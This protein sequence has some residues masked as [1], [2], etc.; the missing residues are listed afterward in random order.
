MTTLTKIFYCIFIIAIT[1]LG[2]MNNTFYIPSLPLIQSEFGISVSDTQLILV[3]GFTFFGLSQLV[4][5]PLTDIF[6]RRPIIIT[7][8]SIFLLGSI[9]CSVATNF[10]LLLLGRIIEGLGIG[11]V[12]VIAR[13]MIRDCFTGDKLL[14]YTSYLTIC[15]LITPVF[16]PFLGGIVEYYLGWHW[17]FIILVI[18]PF[19]LISIALFKLKETRISNDMTLTLQNIKESYNIVLKS[20]RF[21]GLVLNNM[22]TFSGEIAFLT[23]AS[24]LFQQK[25][26]YSA[27]EFS[28]IPLMLLPSVILGN[29]FVIQLV[30]RFDIKKIMLLGMSMLLIGALLMLTFAK[31]TSLS[32]ASLIIPMIIYLFGSGIILPISSAGSMILFSK[33]AGIAGGI[34][35]SIAMLGT[36]LIN[37]GLYKLPVYSQMSLGGL[38]VILSILN[39]VIF[40]SLAWRYWDKHVISS[41]ENT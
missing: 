12:G 29:A 36:G 25:L 5:G 15:F 27:K 11:C 30:K 32:T 1:A 4:Y 8:L 39:F 38:L 31:L 21:L 33:Q 18:S 9:V 6:G 24:F 7:G 23:T 34:T 20:P 41:L 26:G 3:L 19:L 17:I 22:L 40:Y 16:S 37:F 14:K 28:Y 2:Q 10:H 13:A 35:G